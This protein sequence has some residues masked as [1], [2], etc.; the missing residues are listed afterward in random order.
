MGMVDFFDNNIMI[1]LTISSL[2]IALCSAV[3]SMETKLSSIDSSDMTCKSWLAEIN[4]E[5]FGSDESACNNDR[6]CCISAAVNLLAVN[7]IRSISL[8]KTKHDLFCFRINSSR[9]MSILCWRSMVRCWLVMMLN[10]IVSIWNTLQIYIK[11]YVLYQS[12]LTFQIH[13]QLI[14]QN[15]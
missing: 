8:T 5:L 14:T 3:L 12:G 7:L 6:I 2:Y 13:S 10:N 9:V 11:S 1:K 15:S 4:L